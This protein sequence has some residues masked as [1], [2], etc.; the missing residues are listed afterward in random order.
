MNATNLTLLILVGIVL[1][2][3]LVTGMILLIMLLAKQ[4]SGGKGSFGRLAEKYA[5]AK[6]PATKLLPRQTIQVGA[7]VYKRRVSLGVEEQGLYVAKGRKTLLIPW[8]DFKAI[9]ATTLF[10]QKVPLL[11]IGSP[12]VA[13]ISVPRPVFEMMPRLKAAMTRKLMPRPPQE[14]EV[15]HPVEA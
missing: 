4:I 15:E 2:V 13:T 7:V 11:T 3:G 5:V 14:V 12:P 1:L 9:G 10:W 6:P 8:N